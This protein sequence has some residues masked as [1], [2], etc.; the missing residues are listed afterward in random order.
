MPSPAESARR[1]GEQLLRAASLVLL[2]WMAWSLLQ[3]AP[4][5]P[6]TVVTRERTLAAELPAWTVGRAPHR[7]HVIFDT[8][9]GKA[10]R[11]WLRALE[12]TGTAL[13]WSAPGIPALA[14]EVEPAAEPRG[15][16]RV[17]VSAP[18]DPLVTLRDDL[19][20][21]DSAT[22]NGGGV[23]FALPRLEGTAHA[24]TGAQVARA[25]L[26]DSLRLGGVVVIGRA[27]WETRFVAEA[28]EERGWRVELRQVIAPGLEA[29]RGRA[30]SLDTSRVAA[31]IAADS[32]ATREAGRIAA[33]VRSGGGLVLLADAARAPALAALAPGRVDAAVRPTQ[34]A[35]VA[36][37]PRRALVLHPIRAIRGD[38]VPL[39]RGPSGIAA[40]AR[41]VG[42]G[43]VV[44]LGYEDTW[45]WRLS[46]GPD[47]PAA[48]RDWWS[49]VVASVAYRTELPIAHERTGDAS[50]LAS[51]VD[52]LGPASTEPDAAEGGQTATTLPVW[53]LALVS[54]MLLAE[55]GSRRLRGAR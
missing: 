32:T 13:G 9:P 15:G 2:A 29:L 5:A 3:T 43:R 54:A 52:A 31:V 36:D 38:A 46:G 24:A 27:S 8:V 47:A 44:L 10:T 33:F 26:T 20:A 18:G 51:L 6:T 35:F 19:G 14:V 17:L 40:A 50:P 11:D 21:L 12:R 25:P 4:S 28:L 23:V 45:R 55:W 42:D 34:L 16:A 37:A 39:E 53:M 41:R 49:R 7:A 30:A 48:H 22:G 1:I